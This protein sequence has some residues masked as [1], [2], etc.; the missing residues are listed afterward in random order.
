MIPA[1]P[2]AVCG[3][4][5]APGDRVHFRSPWASGGAVVKAAHWRRVPG[6]TTDGHYY[7]GYSLELDDGGQVSFASPEDVTPLP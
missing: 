2:A 6:E 7:L 5:H 1:P 3:E 4:V